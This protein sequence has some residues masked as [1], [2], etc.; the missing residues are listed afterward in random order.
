MSDATQTRSHNAE[1]S[2]AVVTTLAGTRVDAAHVLGSA[3]PRAPATTDPPVATHPAG[4]EDEALSSASELLPRLRLQGRQLARLLADRQQDLDRREAQQNSYAAELDSEMRSARMWLAARQ[5]ELA[6]R[7]SQLSVCERQ[8]ADATSRLAAAEEYHDSA[9]QEAASDIE[10]REAELARSQAELDRVRVRL[11][12]QAEAQLAAQRT[13]AEHRQREHDTLV[14][15][16][17]QLDSHRHKSSEIRRSGLAGLERRRAAIEIE[18]A[19]VERRRTELTEIARHPSPDQ[20]RIAGELQE[21]AEHLAARE[22][23]LAQAEQLQIR[24]EAELDALRCELV[25]ERDRLAEQSR[26]DRRRLVERERTAAAEITQEREA[27]RRRN[28]EVDARQANLDRVR[29]ELTEL[30][31]EALEAR[32]AAEETLAKLAGSAA[33]AAVSRALAEARERLA[34][35]WRLVA[36]RIADERSKLAALGEEMTARSKKLAAQND[37]LAQWVERRQREFDQ[38]AAALAEREEQAREHEKHVR[39]ERDEWEQARLAYEQQL[40][41]TIARLRKSTE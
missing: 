39:G 24:A 10:R 22:Q 36:G 11:E 9:R 33:P 31:R 16:R 17:Q 8:V 29:V 34:D 2:G 26:A 41:G 23:N 40:R 7:E 14:R 37:D 21:I 38:Q 27:L 3:P 13:L 4:S 28:A 20:R 25:K 6:E 18:A 5:Q 1:P 19:A 30:H 12:R 32:L 35:H 15:T